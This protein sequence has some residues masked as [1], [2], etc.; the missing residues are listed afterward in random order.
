MPPKLKIVCSDK[1]KLKQNEI[2]NKRPGD[3][4]KRGLKAGFVAGLNK[5]LKKQAK[6]KPILQELK[7]K[8]PTLKSTKPSLATLIENRPNKATR[9]RDFLTTLPIKNKDLQMSTKKKKE[10]NTEG[11]KQYLINTGEYRR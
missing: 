9:V 3:C 10:L 1:P 11:L 8:P 6:I 4:F 5:M 7:E 2:R